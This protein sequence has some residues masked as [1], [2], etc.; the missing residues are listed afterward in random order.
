MIE[1]KHKEAKVSK[2]TEIL[3]ALINT[4]TSR[5]DTLEKT[6]LKFSI[7]STLNQPHPHRKH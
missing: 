2:G 6:D 3:S 5:E 4:I 7:F 1:E